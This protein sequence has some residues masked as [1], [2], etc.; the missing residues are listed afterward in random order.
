[1]RT[2]LP[3][4]RRKLVSASTA[5]GCAATPLW[6]TP[7]TSLRTASYCPASCLRPEISPAGSDTRPLHEGRLSLA[8][9]AALRKSASRRKLGTG[10]CRAADHR[11]LGEVDAGLV[12][13]HQLLVADGT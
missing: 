5:V 7:Q 8:S 10:R 4:P 13:G 1:M 2:T 9:G 11:T 6:T 12:Q 3:P